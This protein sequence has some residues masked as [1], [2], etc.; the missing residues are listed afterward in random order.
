MKILNVVQHGFKRMRLNNIVHIEYSPKRKKQIFIANNGAGKT[1]FVRTLSPIPSDLSKTHYEGGYEIK[2]IEHCGN[3][4]SLTGTRDG[5]KY[6]FK[7]DNEELNSGGTKRVQLELIKKEFSYDQSIHSIVT[8]ET[9][10]TTMSYNERKEWM[11]R[12]SDI[13]YSYVLSVYNGLRNRLRDVEGG[14]RILNNKLDISD[15]NRLSAE[16]IA[17][18]T[19][20]REILNKTI[21]ILTALRGGGGGVTVINNVTN[22]TIALENILALMPEETIVMANLEKDI[23]SNSEKIVELKSHRENLISMV[24]EVSK[25]EAMDSMDIADIENEIFILENKIKDVKSAIYLNID[26]DKDD[27]INTLSVLKNTIYET[28]IRLENMS[29]GIIDPVE[30]TQTILKELSD[31]LYNFKTIEAKLEET[32]DGISHNKGVL[33]ELKN[34]PEVTCVKCGHRWVDKYDDELYLKYQK[35]YIE[36][37]ENLEK[38]RSAVSTLRGKI[39]LVELEQGLVDNIHRYI[40]NNKL[41]ADI[42]DLAVSSGIDYRKQPSAYINKLAIVSNDIGEWIDEL[43]VL[44]RVRDLKDKINYIKD[45]K[46]NISTIGLYS[47]SVLEGRLINSV[48]MI[49]SYVKEGDLLKKKNKLGT[50]ILSISD[51]LI[52]SIQQRGKDTEKIVDELVG[53]SISNIV[54][55]MKGRVYDINNMLMENE[56]AQRNRNDLKKDITEYDKIKENLK[57]MIRELSPTE[58]LIADSIVGFL[59]TFVYDMNEIIREV[60]SYDIEIRTD[61]MDGDDLTFRF[62]VYVDGEEVSADVGKTSTGMQNIIDL[63]F[64]IV[65]MKRLGIGGYPLVLDEFGQGLFMSH[66]D[67][68]VELL[69]KLGEDMF[70]QMF[71]ITHDQ[72]QYGM[73]GDGGADIIVIGEDAV[74]YIGGEYTYNGVISFIND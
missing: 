33:E 68:A 9:L 58:G 50:E 41:H 48:E 7:K 36:K 11:T 61:G 15:R 71:I 38:V 8:G 56:I 35:S 5:L 37:K 26:V 72:Q 64:K 52:R 67:K 22:Y 25:F 6:S 27:L 44:N 65:S 63:A 66:R 12:I 57:I 55:K 47:S 51:K 14:V 62:P 45:R 40:K 23:I 29:Q 4:Y 10:F 20:E 46:E 34:T 28:H 32:I 19:N 73:F 59:E 49:R 30:S 69:D 18:L 43:S 1:S 31:K 3:I 2:T 70:S 16:Y 13:D 42:N 74:E 53:K 24:E 54:K 21:D 60:W 39:E 17:D